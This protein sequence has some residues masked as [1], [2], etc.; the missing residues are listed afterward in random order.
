VRQILE[1][2]IRK[3]NHSMNSILI[4]AHTPLAS[5]LKSAALHAF[6]D[7]ASRVDVIDVLPDQSPEATLDAARQLLAMERSAGRAGT[8]V[9]SDVFGAT[10]CNVAQKLVQSAGSTHVKCIAGASLPMLLR[11]ITYWDTP[12]AEMAEKAVAGGSQGAMELV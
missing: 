7:A 9:M 12:L 10:P 11:A 4:I 1:A 8:L 6:P 2:I 5:A 3:N